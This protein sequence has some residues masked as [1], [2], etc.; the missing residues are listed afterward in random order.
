MTLAVSEPITQPVTEN[1]MYN[2]LLQPVTYN[3][4][5]NM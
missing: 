1:N 2:V 5:D 4:I 3:N